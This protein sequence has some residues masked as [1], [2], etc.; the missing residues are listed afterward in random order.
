MLDVFYARISPVS[1]C[2][3]V[4]VGEQ[5]YLKKTQKLAVTLNISLIVFEKSVHVCVGAAA[6][7]QLQLQPQ[8]FDGFTSRCAEN[9]GLLVDFTNSLCDHPVRG[10]G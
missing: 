7:E 1:V 10:C 5:I 2:Q 3:T 9:R 6:N 4:T 8:G